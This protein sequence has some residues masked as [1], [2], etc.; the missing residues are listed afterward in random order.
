MVLDLIFNKLGEEVEKLH[1]ESADVK[2]LFH[3]IQPFM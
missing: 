2:I 3:L 1:H